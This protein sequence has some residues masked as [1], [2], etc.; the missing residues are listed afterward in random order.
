MFEVIPAIDL[1]G[2]DVVRLRKGDPGA[3][4]IYPSDPVRL[5]QDFRAAGARRLHLVDLDAA[6]G[7][8]PQAL[9]LLERIV[10][11]GNLDVQYGGGI[12]S[13]ALAQQALSAGASRVIA[14]TA[15][16]EHAGFLDDLAASCGAERVVLAV[17]VR[18]GRLLVRGWQADS[19]RALGDALE[20][21]RRAGVTRL[22]ITDT[23]ADGTLGGIDPSTWEQALDQGF[24]IIAAGGVGSLDD[25]KRLAGMAPRGIEG[26]VVGKALLDGIF[27]LGEAQEAA[28]DTRFAALH[29]ERGR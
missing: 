9:G 7:R 5:A 17:D 1:L 28:A 4:T 24:R 13:C 12:R 8:G 19:G 10:A 29:G 21:A 2:G 16:M 15:A 6:L 20:L 27:T 22:M 3:A 18:G 23:A 25:I 11:L 26:V 14:G